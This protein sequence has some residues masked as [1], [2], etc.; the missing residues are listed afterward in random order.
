MTL[1]NWKCSNNV[2]CSTRVVW[3]L[4]AIVNLQ[5]GRQP[6]G[7]KPPHSCACYCHCCFTSH[8]CTVW[9]DYVISSGVLRGGTPK[10]PRGKYFPRNGWKCGRIANITLSCV[11]HVKLTTV[12]LASG[13]GGAR[14][15][16]KQ[17][18]T[19]QESSQSWNWEKQSNQFAT[20][21]QHHGQ[22]QG[23][24]SAAALPPT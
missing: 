1:Q 16:T 21:S 8:L 23:L 24:C 4:P 5:V 2:L 18:K 13:G 20:M 22:Q 17:R 10:M 11:S 9:R 6:A 7:T 14:A 3:W 19:G 15:R 12:S